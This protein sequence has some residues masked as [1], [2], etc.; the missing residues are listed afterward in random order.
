[1]L[2]PE[3]FDAVLRPK[4]EGAWNLHEVTRDLDLAMFV[5]FSSVAGV[6]GSPGQGNYAAANAFLDGLAQY[7]RGL[8]LA[9][10]SLAWGLWAEGGMAG[11]AQRM[12]GAG[13]PALTVE[14]GLALFDA[15]WGVDR[16]VV[17]PVVLDLPR[18]R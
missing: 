1:S 8:G 13:F 10:Q 2:T 3:R 6:L 9:G 14:Q 12:A 4:V 17:V 16:S 11:D 7:R 5:V 18:L 15:A